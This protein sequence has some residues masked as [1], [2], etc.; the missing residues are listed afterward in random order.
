MFKKEEMKTV[1]PEQERDV[2]RVEAILL[3]ARLRDQGALAVSL[4]AEINQEVVAHIAF[5]KVLID[6]QDQA[7][8]GLAPVAV[9]PEQQNRGIGSR[10][11]AD[12]LAGIKKMGAAGCVVL[13]EA[14][15][16]GRS[17]FTFHAE[18]V[19]SGVPPEYFLG[20]SFSGSFPSGTV[21]YHRAFTEAS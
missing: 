14:E 18:F 1:R 10:L 3:A 11:I 4:V 5:S 8:Y 9:A 15:Y 6:G 13:G 7:W 16:Y 20:L 17:G 21:T 19:L 2:E 12:G